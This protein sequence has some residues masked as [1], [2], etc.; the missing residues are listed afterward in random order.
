MTPASLD[1]ELL[2]AARRGSPVAF[3]RLVERHQR[4]VRAFLRRACGDATE[5]EDLAQETFITAWDLI[6]R[7][8]G[9]A[10]V[11]TWFC[12]I[13]WRKLMTARRSW[14]R[15]RRRDAA[16]LETE[17]LE[18]GEGAGAEDRIALEQALAGLPIDQR[19]AVA[20]CLGGDFSH[21]EAADVLGLPLG[22]VKSHVTRG[23]ARLMQSLGV[24]D[25]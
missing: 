1:A 3:G 11:R 2:E 12:G 15:S 21:A 13:A 16:Y 23:K 19:A 6:G 9:E 14:F 22:T 5:A 17:S 8:R 20:L 24:D 7:F 18:R 4:A 25:A 10:T